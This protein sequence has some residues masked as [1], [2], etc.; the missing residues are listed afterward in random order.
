M[1]SWNGQLYNDGERPV[2][3]RHRAVYYGD[4]LFETLRMVNGELPFWRHHWQRLNLGM[5]LLQL[6]WPAEW[7]AARVREEILR[8]CPGPNARIRLSTL[9]SGGGHYWPG[10]T[11]ADVLIVTSPLPGQRFLLN[12]GGLELGLYEGERISAGSRLANLKTCNALPYILA[13]LFAQ[14]NEWDEA[15]VLNT[16]G[17]IAEA[18]YHNVFVL[19][20]GRLLTPPLSEGPTAGVMRKTVLRLASDWDIPVGEAPLQV[21]DVLAA[22]EVWLTNAIRGVQW[23]RQFENQTYAG[24]LARQMTE[25]LNELVRR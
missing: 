13:G 17:R 8:A 18:S 1:I 4:G 9:R 5:Q 23:V 12:E 14:E 2:A 6:H 24:E 19:Q 7:D 11:A 20:N 10:S 25:Q 3:P 22:D 16:A 21:E 15:L